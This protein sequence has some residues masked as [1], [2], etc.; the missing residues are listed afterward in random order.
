M[1][2]ATVKPHCGHWVHKQDSDAVNLPHLVSAHAWSVSLLVLWMILP[3]S[4]PSSCAPCLAP[5]A[6]AKTVP[7]TVLSSFLISLPISLDH[8]H[9]QTNKLPSDLPSLIKT[10]LMPQ[11]SLA[12]TP[13]LHY[14]YS[15]T[16]EKMDY[17]RHLQFLSSHSCSSLSLIQGLEVTTDPILLK[18]MVK[19]LSPYLL[20]EQILT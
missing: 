6:L 15:K 16:L 4:R 8:S 17:N 5:L 3:R 9:H 7:T 14:P 20:Y 11:P 13:S 2:R 12:D 1:G 10:L 18:A 19:T